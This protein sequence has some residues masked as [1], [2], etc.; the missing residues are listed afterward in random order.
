MNCLVVDFQVLWNVVFS[1]RM[2]Y[3]LKTTVFGKGIFFKNIILIILNEKTVCVYLKYYLIH[4][5]LD[6]V[7]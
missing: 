1:F 6:G 2:W 3:F 7:Q 5:Y 4:T